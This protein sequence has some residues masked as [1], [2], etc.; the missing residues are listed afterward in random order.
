[1]SSSATIEAQETKADPGPVP[2]QHCRSKPTLPEGQLLASGTDSHSGVEK[3]I[4]EYFVG[5][6]YGLYSLIPQ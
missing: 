1:M 5:I 2:A 3:G 4:R 6:R